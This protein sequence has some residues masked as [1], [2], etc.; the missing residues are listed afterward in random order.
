MKPQVAPYL[1]AVVVLGAAGWALVHKQEPVPELPPSAAPEAP[2][3]PTANEGRLPP[4][5]PPLPQGSSPN[6][7]GAMP[8]MP[9]MSAGDDDPAI[10]WT[11][12]SG[13]QN[14]PNA[15]AMR[16]A[17]YH[18]SPAVDVSVSRAGGATDANIQRWLH[19]FDGAAV[20][21]R[22]DTT[23]KGIDVHEVEVSGTYLGG[24][25]MTGTASEPHP[26]WSLVGAVVET[27][28]SHYFFKMVGP[29]DQVGSAKAGF[30]ALVHSITPK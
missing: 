6:G 9:A 23:V 7:A 5:H 12:P 29:A 2:P 14:A 27:K 30:D 3:S 10:A 22:T 13:W 18:P 20:P 26:G 8:A 16:L 24:G 15:S 4:N 17:T 25:M 1:A 21:K 19:Q 28:G 11:V